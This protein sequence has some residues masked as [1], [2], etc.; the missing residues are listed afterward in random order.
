MRPITAHEL[1]QIENRA[2]AELEPV[3][4]SV[5]IPKDIYMDLLEIVNGDRN[6]YGCVSDAINGAIRLMVKTYKSNKAFN[7]AIKEILG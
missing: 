5:R 7:D 1:Q 6:S 3:M 4:C 2:K